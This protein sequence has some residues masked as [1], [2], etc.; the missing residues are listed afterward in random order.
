MLPGATPVSPETCTAN[1][2][3][4]RR[5]D[6]RLVSLPGIWAVVGVA[7]YGADQAPRDDRSRR[8]GDRGKVSMNSRRSSSTSAS[9]AARAFRSGFEFGFCCVGSSIGLML[10]LVALAS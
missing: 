3:Y 4:T 8:G 2:S 5:T 6:L 9:A 7:V 1:R 10:M